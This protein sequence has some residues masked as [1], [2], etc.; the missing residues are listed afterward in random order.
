MSKRLRIPVI[1]GS[2]FEQSNCSR[3]ELYLN[4]SRILHLNKNAI[5]DRFI[6]SN[7]VYAFLYKDFAILSNM[8]RDLLE[9][10]LIKQGALL[11]YL[12]ANVEVIEERMKARGDDYV[13]TEMVPLINKKYEQV[14]NESNMK[15]L[16][17]DTGLYS[18]NEIVEMILYSLD[19]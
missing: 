12:H 13:K 18:S 16:K 11:V 19:Y 4:F 2:T 1:K 3:Q 9:D 7:L 5:I 10:D 8:Q 15:C 17:I 14:L 6:Y